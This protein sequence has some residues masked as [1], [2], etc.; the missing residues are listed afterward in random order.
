MAASITACNL[1]QRSDEKAG[2]IEPAFF[3][4]A[5]NDYLRIGRRI[6]ARL[7]QIFDRFC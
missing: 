2:S 5:K 4:S 6:F 7:L 1:P 3:W